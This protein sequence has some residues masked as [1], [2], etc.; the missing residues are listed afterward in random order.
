MSRDTV[1]SHT[2]KVNISGREYPVNVT[3]DNEADMR[4]AV[5]LINE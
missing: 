4:K 2:I 5:A 3:P 1:K